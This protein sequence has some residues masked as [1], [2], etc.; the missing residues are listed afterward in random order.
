VLDLTKNAQKILGKVSLFLNVSI[1]LDSLFLATCNS[2]DTLF[3][4][5]TVELFKITIN[6]RLNFFI[7][8]KSFTTE[9]FLHVRREKIIQ[10]GYIWQIW[11]SRK[12]FEF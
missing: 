7:V 5:K 10:G 2:F 1:K 4:V 6:H 12:Q 9:S 8:S 3:I 11:C